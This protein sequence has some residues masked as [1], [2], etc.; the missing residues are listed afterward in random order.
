[1]GHGPSAF[2]YGGLDQA[3][4]KRWRIKYYKGLGTSSSAEVRQYNDKT[5]TT[6]THKT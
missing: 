2:R 3:Q 6:L 1:M 5:T 4:R